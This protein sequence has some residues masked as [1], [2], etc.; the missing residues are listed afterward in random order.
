MKEKSNVI[1]AIIVA[2]IV[3]GF[4]VS[5]SEDYTSEVIVDVTVQQAVIIDVT[6]DAISFSGMP[7]EIANPNSAYITIY[8]LGSVPISNIKISVELPSQN[9]WGSNNPN[10][11]KSG[12]FVLVE[13]E[14]SNIK[15]VAQ[16]LFSIDNPPKYMTFPAECM[17]NNNFDSTKCKLFLFRTAKVV[18]NEGEDWFILVIS[19]S[20][21]KF[22]TSDVKVRFAKSPK[23]ATSSGILSFSD[24]SQYDEK[25]L[26][27]VN[28][29][30]YVAHTIG[31]N[32]MLE[33]YFVINSDGTEAYFGYWDY[34]ITDK[35]NLPT[36]YLRST[37]LNPA[38]FVNFRVQVR[39]PYGVPMGT[40]SGKLFIVASV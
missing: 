17:N 35:V 27:A 4:Y 20:N 11:H 13:D 18:T 26:T 7:G 29:Y 34:N 23:T 14:S 8:N 12:E 31:N 25:Y 24:A 16:R 6:P 19:D 39:I 30:G 1:L 21:K 37:Q 2:F 33:G 9:P 38:E 28:E 36:N 3:I 5:F 15:Y 32:N 40:V 10:L 22:N